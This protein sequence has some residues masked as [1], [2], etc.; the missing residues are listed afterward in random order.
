M[1]STHNPSSTLTRR[2]ISPMPLDRR[3]NFCGAVVPVVRFEELRKNFITLSETD[4]M[5]EDQW[6]V[7]PSP[8]Y[9]RHFSLRRGRRRLSRFFLNIDLPFQERA[10]FNGDA[11][12]SHIAGY[13][14]RLPQVHAIGG[15][16]SSV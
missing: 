13:H 11:L 8:V 2:E 12:R 6:R 15:D 7:Y 1:S 10:F 16:H 5:S 4:A 3:V 9:A 14:R